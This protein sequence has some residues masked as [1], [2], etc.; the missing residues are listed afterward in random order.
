MSFLCH[1]KSHSCLERRFIQFK[2]A[3]SEGV[4]IKRR[5]NTCDWR[6]PGG[7]SSGDDPPADS[8]GRWR[9]LLPS[10]TPEKQ[11]AN[12]KGTE[13]YVQ[14]RTKGFFLQNN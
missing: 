1:R 2:K 6:A 7:D 10:N 13:S 14:S 4:A 8:Y 5:E 9:W 11:K 3:A 12:V